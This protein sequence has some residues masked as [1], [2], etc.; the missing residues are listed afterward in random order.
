MAEAGGPALSVAQAMLLQTWLSPAYPVG[1]F[2]WSHGLETLVADGTLRDGETLCDWI[3]DVLRHGGGWSDAVLFA[4]GWRAAGDA[5]G[6]ARLE[7]LAAALSPSAERLAETIGQGAA[8]AAV[9]DAVAAAG[10]APGD[11]GGLGGQGGL[12]GPR[13]PV[14]PAATDQGTD[15]GGPAY[16]LAV[17]RASAGAGIALD[18]ALPS[19]LLALSANLVS[20]GVRLIPL[21]Q[22]D[23]QLVLAALAPECR[24]VASAAAAAP[25]SALGGV[26]ILSDIASMRHEILPTRL[27]RS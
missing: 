13:K 22:T 6:F 8:F 11:G 5:E 20:A 2:A 14:A 1:A 9:N 27:F 16:P 24:A 26:A 15:G 19:V 10:S 25:L 7:A 12:G 23:G 4:H 3:T 17:A 18:A 21:G